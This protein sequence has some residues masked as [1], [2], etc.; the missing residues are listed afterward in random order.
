MC[1]GATEICRTCAWHFPIGSALRHHMTHMTHI[2]RCGFPSTLIY[3]HLSLPTKHTNHRFA[4]NQDWD[5]TSELNDTRTNKLNLP[6]IESE[7][8]ILASN[9]E[10]TSTSSQRT[11]SP[12]DM[13]RQPRHRGLVALASTPS[14]FPARPRSSLAPTLDRR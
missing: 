12:P 8:S 6:L 5:G 10:E 4:N 13:C 3:S 9:Q 1:V 7:L 2:P 14:P 11:V